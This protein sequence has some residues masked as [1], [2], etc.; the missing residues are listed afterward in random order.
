[1]RRLC[2]AVW[3]GVSVMIAGPVAAQGSDQAVRATIEKFFTAF[4]SGS[5]SAAT[6]L[7]RRDAVD[8]NFSGLI[9]GAD[10]L[11]KRIAA[12]LKLGVK[13][14]HTIDRIEVEGQLAWAAG[15]YGV[16]IPSKDG[17]STQ[18]VGAWLQVLKQDGGIWK[19]QAV[20]FTRVD[21]PK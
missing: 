17:Q 16:T 21:P 18:R 15:H 3:L 8:I 10:Q 5:V 7:W 9:S 1:M 2:A 6:E 4:N 19:F 13:F 14:D 12:E 20:S 11:E